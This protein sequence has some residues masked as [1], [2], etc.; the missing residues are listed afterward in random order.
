[1][2]IAQKRL[3]RFAEDWSSGAA[4][5]NHLRSKWCEVPREWD[6]A[7]CDL[8]S[9]DLSGFD[10]SGMRFEGANLAKTRLNGANLD[11]ADF[12]NA[13][14]E[15]VSARESSVIFA[16]FH[17]AR[18]T[19]TDFSNSY[20]AAV[21]LAPRA[22]FD[23]RLPVLWTWSD[24]GRSLMGS[25]LHPALRAVA[26]LIVRGDVARALADVSAFI[27]ENPAS[28]YA[29]FLRAAIYRIRHQHP[30]AEADERL[31]IQFWPSAGRDHVAMV[32]GAANSSL[33]RHRQ[34]WQCPRMA[35]LPKDTPDARLLHLNA[36][37]GPSFVPTSYF[38][39]AVASHVS[40]GLIVPHLAESEA[41]AAR[42]A[43][44]KHLATWVTIGQSFDGKNLV[45]GAIIP[46]I[47]SCLNRLAAEVHD[48][49]IADL[50]SEQV[51]AAVDAV[52]KYDRMF[53][54]PGYED[55]MLGEVERFFR[56][57][58]AKVLR[59]LGNSEGEIAEFVEWN[60]DFWTKRHQQRERE[61]RVDEMRSKIVWPD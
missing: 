13:N 36:S 44:E 59:E 9:I 28:S 35:P 53:Y 16:R 27:G 12:R 38:W 2:V 41:S 56:E 43:Y 33:A 11:R 5:W 17:N 45:G 55:R 34:W 32:L 51:R 8:S 7:G 61:R 54:P 3:R 58:A 6:L 20:L 4:D 19:G 24:A 42:L 60:A 1:M 31:T 18:I 52:M 23:L 15:G 21:G 57:D 46:T 25:S 14:L 10:L 49:D 48:G 37:L 22:K 50:C 26:E 30:A 40:S 39:N 47:C 29:F